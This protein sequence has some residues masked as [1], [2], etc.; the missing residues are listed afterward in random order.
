MLKINASTKDVALGFLNQAVT[1]YLLIAVS[2][3]DRAWLVYIKCFDIP[4][5]H[6]V[7]AAL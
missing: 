3:T 7:V 5:F 6:T 1:K 2:Y 4:A